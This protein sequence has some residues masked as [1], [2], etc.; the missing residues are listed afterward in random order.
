MQGFGNF[1]V[2]FSILILLI[3]QLLQLMGKLFYLVAMMLLAKGVFAQPFVDPLQV[4]YTYGFRTANAYATPFTHAWVG[5]DVPIKLK[6]KTYLLLSPFY[7]QWTIDS[8]SKNNIV[9]SVKSLA[10]PVGLI[11]PL[12]KKWTLN[13]LPIIR[14]N[15][16]QLLKEKTFQIGGVGFA[17]YAVTP[18]KKFRF[19][20]YMNQEFFGLFVWPLLGADW[21]LGKKDY[22]FGLLPGRLTYEHQ[23]NKWLYGGITFRALTNS[24]RLNDG[25]FLRIDDNQLSLYMDVYAAKH[26]CVTL[27]PGYG[28]SRKLRTGI[29]NNSYLSVRNMGDGP[30]IKFSTAYRLRL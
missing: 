25:R 5:S 3:P 28:L 13:L 16:Q 4:R 7:E 11:L 9:P 2:A 20:V 15:G 22:V 6:E 21:R 18:Q 24:F 1:D 26:I 17:T 10:F 29:N 8:A 14:T 12:N 30:F 23:W 19:G 27:E